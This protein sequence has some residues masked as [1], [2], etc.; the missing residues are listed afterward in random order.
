MDQTQTSAAPTNALSEYE[1]LS[2][3]TAVIDPELGLDIVSL[4][5]VYA[6]AIGE[7][8]VRITHTLTSPGCPLGAEI[9]A[10]MVTE[11]AAVAGGRAVKPVLV[12]S[13][14]WEPEHMSEDVKF[15]LGM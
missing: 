3:L 15:A 10:A 1:V 9:A 6:V 5:L 4:G 12:F 7:T 14:P 2:A 11:V 8:E 13:P